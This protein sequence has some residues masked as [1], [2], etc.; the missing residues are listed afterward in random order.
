MSW[1]RFRAYL[2]KVWRN[3]GWINRAFRITVFLAHQGETQNSRPDRQVNID[4]VHEN[5]DRRISK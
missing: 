4:K 5:T 3:V 2:Q 1:Q